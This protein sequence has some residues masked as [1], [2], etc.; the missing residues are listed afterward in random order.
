MPKN[1]V[2]VLEELERVRYVGP[3]LAEALY[4]DHGVRTIADIVE[5]GDNDKLTELKGV[6]TK[7]AKTIL[8]SARRIAD[9]DTE[10]DAGDDTAEA[11]GE[12]SEEASDEETGDEETGDEETGDDEEADASDT[13]DDGHEA[14]DETADDEATDDDEAGEAQ[15]DLPPRT[16]GRGPR[17]P[18]AA[19]PSAQP[20]A[21]TGSTGGSGGATREATSA[22]VRSDGAETAADRTLR[23]RFV[24]TLRCPACGNESFE[25]GST[26]L[27]CNACQRQFNLQNGIADLAPPAPPNRSLT[28]KVMESRTYTRFYEEFL[29][30]KLTS[31]VSQRSMREEYRLAADFLDFGDDIR[32]LDV[33]C[34]TGNFTRYLAQR[35]GLAETPATAPDLPL[36]VGMDLSWPMLEN[37][38]RNIRQENLEDKVFLLRGDGTRI[39]VRRGV[40][41]RVH[42]AGT[43]HMMNDIDEGL[44]NFARVLEPNGVCVIGTFVLGKGLLRRMLK[45]AA[46]FPTEFHWFSR[47][48]LLRR[49]ERA[50]FEISD[51]S[52]AGDAITVKARRI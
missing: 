10:S 28:Q 44:R 3:K 42:C 49:I 20:S 43:L 40:Y 45:R 22:K 2:K 26:T 12:T 33:G 16:N 23:Q 7:T 25:L 9:T 29:R 50:G 37:A 14:Q 38:R 19:R 39:P 15:E 8:S 35:I 41:N 47:D 36:V 34:G 27:T 21:A 52:Q 31:V 48:E 1:K 5:F 18:A 51:H 4:D 6:G 30:P 11:D 24:D 32:L 13:G 17:Q 46:E